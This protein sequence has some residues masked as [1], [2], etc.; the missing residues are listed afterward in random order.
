[1]VDDIGSLLLTEFIEADFDVIDGFTEHLTD[2]HTA[3]AS[4]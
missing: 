4:N 2:D 3:D 1:M